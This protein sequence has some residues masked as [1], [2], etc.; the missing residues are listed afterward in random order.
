MNENIPT[1]VSGTSIDMTIV[2]PDLSPDIAWTVAPSPSV[3]S[4][5]HFPIVILFMIIPHPAVK[6]SEEGWNNKKGK[7]EEYGRHKV[8]SH[9][10][11]ELPDDSHS[12]L[13]GLY[14]RFRSAEENCIPKYK[15]RR[16]YA[17]HWWSSECKASWRERE[18]C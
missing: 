15:R 1:H 17:K 9:L 6:L 11:D 13:E 3:L 4:S 14:P 2:S 5:D 18:K 10:N 16:F 12:I 8:W 7:W